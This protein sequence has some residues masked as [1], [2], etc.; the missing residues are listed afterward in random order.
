M[1]HVVDPLARELVQ[2]LA[3]RSD[4]LRRRARE[5]VPLEPVD[6]SLGEQGDVLVD[7][8]LHERR[9]LGEAGL[10]LRRQAGRLVERV[11]VTETAGAALRRDRGEAAL[12]AARRRP[13][14]RPAGPPGPETV[15]AWRA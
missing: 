8:P 2:Q 7:L 14:R 6:P 9:Q 12:D 13:R 11:D 3:R 4:R 1:D 10:G 15:A 5:E